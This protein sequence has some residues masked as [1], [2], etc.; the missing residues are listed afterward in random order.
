[1]VFGGFW[2]KTMKNT[3]NN[4]FLDFKTYIS[5]SPWRKKMDAYIYC[6]GALKMDLDLKNAS[7]N[8]HLGARIAFGLRVALCCEILHFEASENVWKHFVFRC[9]WGKTMK[10]N[11]NTCFLE[12]TTS[13]PASWPSQPAQSHPLPKTYENRR[14]LKVFGGKLWKTYVIISFW[15]SKRVFQPA[16]SL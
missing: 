4:C 5:R 11:G 2:R 13:I 6:A 9:F 10:N 3:C 1:M 8:W 14:F 7:W 12:V 15:Q 16:S